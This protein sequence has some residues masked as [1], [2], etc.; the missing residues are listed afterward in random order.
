LNHIKV[1]VHQLSPVVPNLQK[2]NA[3]VGIQ[4][5]NHHSGLEDNGCRHFSFPPSNSN[6]LLRPAEHLHR[7]RTGNHL[8][9][10]R[11]NV[12]R[13]GAAILASLFYLKGLKEKEKK[14]KGEVSCCFLGR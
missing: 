2:I 7:V 4:V 9:Q 5:L 6:R 11:S 10:G 3:A 1:L 14:R 13:E 8:A 12:E